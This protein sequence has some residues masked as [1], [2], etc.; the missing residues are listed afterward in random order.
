M[1]AHKHRSVVGI[2]SE[3]SGVAV[4]GVMEDKVHPPNA[5]SSSCEGPVGES[6]VILKYMSLPGAG[7]LSVV[8]NWK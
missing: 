5:N 1:I 2:S 7:L 4:G 6:A 8:M 3:G